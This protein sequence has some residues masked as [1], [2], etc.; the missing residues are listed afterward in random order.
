MKHLALDFHFVREKVSAGE[1]KVLHLS[2]TDQLADL[3]TKPLS[4]PRF[5]FLRD[6]LS[7]VADSPSLR[8]RVE[9][10]KSPPTELVDS[11]TEL[12][13]SASTKL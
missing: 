7:T 1:I 12:T 11:P 4:R 8:G 3:L 2:S 9:I 6:K 5:Q 10:S 13:V